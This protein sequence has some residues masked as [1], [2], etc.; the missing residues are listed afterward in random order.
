MNNNDPVEEKM[1]RFV[2]LEHISSWRRLA[3]FMWGEHTSPQVLGFDDVNMTEVQR[4]APLLSEA[5]GVKVTATHFAVKTMGT[6]IDRYPDLNV[7]MVRGQPMRRKTVD[8]FVQVAIQSSGVGGAD[9]SGI[10]VKDVNK[11]SVVEIAREISERSTRVRKGQDKN[12]ESTKRLMDAVPRPILG[13]LLKGVNKAMFDAE[14]DLGRLGVKFDPFGSAMIT[15]CA[16]FGVHA[17][18]APLIP[19]ARTPLIF[20]LGRTDPKPVV[21]N[22]TDVVVRPV[23]RHAGTFDHRLLDGYQIGLI[24]SEYKKLMEDPE[25]GGMDLG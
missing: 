24:C 12:I 25:G 11:K 2:P 23:C 6:V 17:G 8:I 9:L 5:S 3:N 21:E 16:S 18:F 13:A 20:L 7:L 14:V 19:L 1:S 10:K 4:L 15:N 22:G